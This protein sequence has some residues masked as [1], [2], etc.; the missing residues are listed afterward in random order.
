MA[1][2]EAITAIKAQLAEIIPRGVPR[3]PQPVERVYRAGFSDIRRGPQYRVHN[4][5]IEVDHPRTREY[6]SEED[7]NAAH[8]IAESIVDWLQDNQPGDLFIWWGG[9]GIITSVVEQDKGLLIEIL[10]PLCARLPQT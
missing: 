4:V 8:A 6:V 1:I 9:G 10:V 2:A 5:V 7:T 3:G